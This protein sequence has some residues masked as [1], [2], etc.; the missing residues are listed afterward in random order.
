MG[1]I[2]LGGMPGVIAQPE[3]G[4]RLRRR[5]IYDARSAFGVAVVALKHAGRKIFDV[6]VRRTSTRDGSTT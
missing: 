5:A 2:V 6:N 1:H 3:C 4:Q